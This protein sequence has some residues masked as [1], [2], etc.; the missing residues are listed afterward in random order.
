MLWVIGFYSKVRAG[1]IEGLYNESFDLTKEEPVSLFKNNR[2]ISSDILDRL[3]LKDPEKE[4]DISHLEV[5]KIVNR[6]DGGLLIFGEENYSTIVNYTSPNVYNVY[7]M[8]N[9]T[10]FHYN[11]VLVTAINAKGE[12]QWNNILRKKQMIENEQSFVS[13][14]V[15]ILNDEVRCYYNNDITRN[16]TL[17]RSDILSNGKVNSISEFKELLY[18][19]QCVQ[20]GRKEWVGLISDNGNIRLIKYMGQ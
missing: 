3:I 6:S 18:I 11:N 17:M 1:K 4:Q 19:E 2:A 8:N 15:Y 13:C 16:N 14:F 10:Y 12:I 5:I 9:I 20:T 7:S